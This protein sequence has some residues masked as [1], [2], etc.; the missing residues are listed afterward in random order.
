[1]I[2]GGSPLLVVDGSRRPPHRRPSLEV[3]AFPR[4]VCRQV[5]GKFAHAFLGCVSQRSSSDFLP[6]R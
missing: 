5:A 3:W 2:K 1:M 6:L 4:R